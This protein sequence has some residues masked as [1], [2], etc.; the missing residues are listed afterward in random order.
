MSALI[1]ISLL[2]ALSV[3]WYWRIPPDRANASPLLQRA[4]YYTAIGPQDNSERAIA[5]YQQRLQEAPDDAEALAGLS[6]AHSARVC[7]FNG[8]QDAAV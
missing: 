8:D 1:A 5:L 4:A 3:L 6:R 2:L 7:L